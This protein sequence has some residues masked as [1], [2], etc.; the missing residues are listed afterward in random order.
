MFGQWCFSIEAIRYMTRTRKVGSSSPDVA[1]IR[2]AQLSK[3]L[4]LALLQEGRFG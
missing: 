1:T 3:A 4:N 2:S